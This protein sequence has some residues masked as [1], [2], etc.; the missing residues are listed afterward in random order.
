MVPVPKDDLLEGNH[1]SFPT[2]ASSQPR[3]RTPLLVSPTGLSNAMPR[4]KSPRHPDRK[5]FSAGP[6]LLAAE[7]FHN[8]ASEKQHQ[9]VTLPAPVTTTTTDERQARGRRTRSRDRIGRFQEGCN[10]MGTT[11][12]MIVPERLQTC[13]AQSARQSREFAK[14]IGPVAQ[15]G[16]RGCVRGTV[17]ES[18]YVGRRMTECLASTSDIYQQECTNN[19]HHRGDDSM[20]FVS[21]EKRNFARR[22]A[23]SLDD[24][25]DD[26]SMAIS[27]GD[28]YEYPIKGNTARA[29]AS[30]VHKGRSRSP[31]GGVTPRKDNYSNRYSKSTGGYRKSES[32][33]G[34]R[35]VNFS[36]SDYGNPHE[37][38]ES[39]ASPSRSSLSPPRK[40]R[41]A[42]S[43]SDTGY[44]SELTEST[45]TPMR[46]SR[47]PILMRKSPIQKNEYVRTPP[48]V[49]EP[50]ED[51]PYRS[52]KGLRYPE[53]PK[54]MDD[55]YVTDPPTPERD[56]LRRPRGAYDQDDS[57]EFLKE[58]LPTMRQPGT[59]YTNMRDIRKHMLNKDK[60]TGKGV[61]EGPLS[62]SLE[63]LKIHD[64]SMKTLETELRETKNMLE[65]TRHELTLTRKSSAQQKQV[66]TATAEKLFG[67]RVDIE[68]KLRR[69]MRE[70]DNLLEQI[71]GLRNEKNRLRTT[72]NVGSD[73][74]VESTRIPDQTLRPTV[75][76]SPSRNEQNPQ[77]PATPEGLQES[78]DRSMYFSSLVISLRAE[79]LELK[80]ELAEAR[81]AQLE[82]KQS[83]REIEDDKV[84]IGAEGEKLKE[85]VEQLK[86]EIKVLEQEAGEKERDGELEIHQLQAELRRM[87]DK[88]VTTA[89]DVLGRSA[90]HQR[91]EKVLNETQDEATKLRQQ[92]STLI[93]K[94]ETLEAQY[95]DRNKVSGVEAKKLQGEISALNEKLSKSHLEII[96]QATEHLQERKRMEEAL[97]QSRQEAHVLQS[98]VITLDDQVA[99]AEDEVNQMRMRMYDDDKASRVTDASRSSQIV[100]YMNRKMANADSSVMELFR[101]KDM[102]MTPDSRFHTN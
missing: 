50:D 25:H 21:A 53:A 58:P 46:K 71:S 102:P 76:S 52:N 45:F 91:T 31:T 79:I 60:N 7:H 27:D 94:V 8:T 95:D 32:P 83:Q 77:C 42:F 29:R 101:A 82:A 64:G 9:G 63:E 59:E 89:Q 23:E 14:K 92:V 18:M 73:G 22:A 12:D 41:L 55:C 36:E 39:S 35:R 100:R 72:L 90:D 5:G 17:R 75:L 93:S 37:V 38:T 33:T 65:Q 43:D 66:G 51:A 6:G 10:N 4:P 26:N 88:L 70:N 78:A 1:D 87:Q 20:F 67:D 62:R 19:H 44:P 68:E 49:A 54:I 98:K 80:S 2:T 86:Q 57:L 99:A 11:P 47:S 3:A 24:D 30:S 56:S 28:D 85:Q 61:S 16:L 40:S 97:S 84:H 69:E 96:G 48:R 13:T 74:Q 81:A 15:D 34:K